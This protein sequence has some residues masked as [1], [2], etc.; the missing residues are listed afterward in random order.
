MDIT[1]IQAQLTHLGFDGWLF[2]DFRRSNRIA[3]RILNLPDHLVVTRRWYYYIPREGEASGLVSA[4]EPT[5]LDTL[6][7][8]KRVYR[9]WQERQAFLQALL[10]SGSRIAMEYSPLNAIPYVSRVDAGTVDLV[11]SFGIEVVSSAD[12]VQEAVARWSQEQWQGHLQASASLIQIK[13][14]AFAE[15]ARAVRSGELLT[16]YALQQFMARLYR[17]AGLVADEPPIVATNQRCSNPH[18]MPLQ[19]REAAINEGDVLMLD[20]W[21]KLDRPG[22]VYADHTWMAYVGER[23]PERVAEIFAIVAGARDRAIAFLRTRI[24]QGITVRGWEVDA[25]ARDFINQCGYGQYFIHRTGH[26]IDEAVHGDGANMDDYETHDERI[27]MQD[28]AFSIEPGIYL[29]EFGVRSEV[30][31]FLM[32]NELIVTG[33]PIQTAV[34][35]LLAPDS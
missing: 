12:M 13:D 17:D 34:V 9:T 1:E 18:Y 26:S 19:S 24:E 31:A 35:P 11:R 33:V 6:P 29:P 32:G 8:E 10:P 16:D 3:Y 28:T 4:L 23:V 21:A 14:R 22:S 7:G 30:N 20:F 27:V 5:N 25:A 2:F 15:V